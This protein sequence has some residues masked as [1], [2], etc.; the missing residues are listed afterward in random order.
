ML[1]QEGFKP[2]MGVKKHKKLL[3]DEQRRILDFY[4]DFESEIPGEEAE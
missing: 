4:Q 3:T 1:Y 2:V